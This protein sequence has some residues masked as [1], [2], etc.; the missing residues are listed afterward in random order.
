MASTHT[1]MAKVVVITAVMGAILVIFGIAVALGYGY[2]GIKQPTQAVGLRSGVCSVSD[3]D[4]Y[5]GFARDIK[6]GDTF[7]TLAS[8]IS[9]RAGFDSDPN[10]LYILAQH[11]MKAEHPDTAR[12]YVDTLSTL[13]K[14]GIYADGRF[15]DLVGIDILYATVRATATDQVDLGQG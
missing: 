13:S 1:G 15:N 2:I 3:I 9:K 12:G 10:C 8:D 4:K 14:Q 7:N 6:V 5:N 11:E